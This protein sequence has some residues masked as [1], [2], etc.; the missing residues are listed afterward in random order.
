MPGSNNEGEDNE[1]EEA[2][3]GENPERAANEK[4]SQGEADPLLASGGSADD[5]QPA[6]AVIID[7]DAQLTDGE[8]AVWDDA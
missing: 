5:E 8:P 4:G 2:A 6:S 7:Q 3:S 1:A